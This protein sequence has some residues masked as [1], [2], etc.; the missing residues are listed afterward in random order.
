[1]RGA[2]LGSGVLYVS[3]AYI[4]LQG[5]FS[6]ARGRGKRVA[7]GWKLGDSR[8]DRSKKTIFTLPKYD[9]S[10]ST[11]YKTSTPKL[12]ATAS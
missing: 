1:M 8:H 3:D 11:R 2:K 6:D 4:K 9:Y 5:S 7:C 12:K 10:R